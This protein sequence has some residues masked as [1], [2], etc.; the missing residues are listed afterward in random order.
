MTPDA[1]TAIAAFADQVH[2]LL[3]E[4]ALSIGAIDVAVEV[5]DL[6]VDG[7]VL[8]GSG[9]DI[10][11]T[12]DAEAGA[13]SYCELVPPDSEQWLDARC[14]GFDVLGLPA[15]AAGDEARRAAALEL[16]QGLLDARRPLLKR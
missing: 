9:P 7:E 10:G 6:H 4:R 5:N 16:L 11:F 1:E 12:L 8:F 3:H 2:D 15:G 13:C 14:D